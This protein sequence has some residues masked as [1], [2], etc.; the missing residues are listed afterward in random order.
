MRQK[1]IILLI[2]APRRFLA[3]F[4][5]FKNFYEIKCFYQLL[6]FLLQEEI[7]FFNSNLSF[8]S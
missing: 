2:I 4:E 6:A 3:Y 8:I 7:Y 5:L 1:K